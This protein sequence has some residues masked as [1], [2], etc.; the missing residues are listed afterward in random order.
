MRKIILTGIGLL[1][2]INATYMVAFI[3]FLLL[4]GGFDSATY[5][6]NAVIVL[7]SGIRGEKLT[8]G[9]K[10]R[11]DAAIRYLCNQQLSYLSRRRHCAGRRF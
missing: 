1:L 11:L 10:N 9:L 2:M 5:K 7:G 4:Y 6:E 8:E 3:S